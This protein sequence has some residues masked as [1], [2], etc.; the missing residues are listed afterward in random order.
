MLTQER[1]SSGKRKT[2]KEKWHLNVTIVKR[3][4]AL[5]RNEIVKGSWT[6][7]A[8]GLEE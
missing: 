6:R 7:L 5:K 1:L 2:V 3:S 4:N 8:N